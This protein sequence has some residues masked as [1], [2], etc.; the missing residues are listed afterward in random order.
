MIDRYERQAGRKCG[1]AAGVEPFGRR[2]AGCRD[3]RENDV[4]EGPATHG[5]LTRLPAGCE[6]IHSLAGRFCRDRGG[7]WRALQSSVDPQRRRVRLPTAPPT[8]NALGRDEMSAIGPR[9]TPRP[10]AWTIDS[11]WHIAGE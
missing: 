5:H 9:C 7:R 11:G 3:G 8:V 2:A 4:G 10:G 1:L 6:V